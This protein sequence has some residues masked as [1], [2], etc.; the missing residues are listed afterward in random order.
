MEIIRRATSS[1]PINPNRV[2]VAIGLGATAVGTPIVSGGVN[3][4][5]NYTTIGTAP[6]ALFGGILNVSGDAASGS[7]VRIFISISFDAGVTTHITDYP[8][9][10]GASGTARIDLTGFAIPNAADIRIKIQASSA[11]QTLNC[12]LIGFQRLAGDPPGYASAA[13]ILAVGSSTRVSS[14]DVTLSG[15]VTTY[16]ELVPDTGATAYAG[17]MVTMQAGTSSPAAAQYWSG[18]I[19]LG[20]QNFEVEVAWLEAWAVNSATALVRATM[21]P[22]L[23]RTIPAN[24]RIAGRLTAASAN[25]DIGRFGILGLVS[26]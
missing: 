2:N 26:A 15:G 16:T 14:V 1:S 18:A 13:P 9:T 11:T 21:I 25:G 12:W 8:L 24:Q 3:A 17:L 23:Q 10:S 19:T 4:Y 7:G 6:Y 5:G 20:A 22:T